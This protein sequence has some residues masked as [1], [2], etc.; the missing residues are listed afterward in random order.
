[1]RRAPCFVEGR[2]DVRNDSNQ[3][4]VQEAVLLEEMGT[5][6]KESVYIRVKEEN[7]TQESWKAKGDLHAQRRSRCLFVL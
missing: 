5:Q 3:I 7:H 4:I 2:I 1:M 6:R